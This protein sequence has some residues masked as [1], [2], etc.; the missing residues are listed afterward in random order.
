MLSLN[1]I[2]I[3]SPVEPRPRKDQGVRWGELIGPCTAANFAIRSHNP[4]LIHSLLADLLPRAMWVDILVLAI[5]GAGRDDSL[6]LGEIARLV[7]VVLLAEQQSYIPVC[8][9][10]Y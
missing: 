6:R 2:Q 9:L 5:K 3:Q 7:Q 8:S 10:A 1:I 4:L